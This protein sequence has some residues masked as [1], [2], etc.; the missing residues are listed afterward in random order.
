MSLTVGD[1]KCFSDAAYDN[2]FRK[3]DHMTNQDHTTCWPPSQEHHHHHQA[4]WPPPV[5]SLFS[6]FSLA[7]QPHVEQGREDKGQRGDKNRRNQLEKKESSF[8]S[9]S[10]PTWRIPENVGNDSARK[11]RKAMINVRNTVLLIVNSGE[12][13]YCC[14]C[15]PR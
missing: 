9:I 11:R 2:L 1:Y 3:S 13:C 10:F 14:C 6:I 4:W 5:V 12:E 8:S 15:Q 7:G